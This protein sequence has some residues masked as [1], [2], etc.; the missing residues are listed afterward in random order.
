MS[1]EPIGVAFKTLGCKV[2]QVESEDI[3]ADLLGRGVVL[4]DEPDA[5]VVV[6]NTCT[7]TGEADAKA[8]KAVRHALGAATRPVVV[9]TG[10]MAALARDDLEAISERVVVEADKARVAERVAVELELRDESS[11]GASHSGRG[12][13]PAPVRPRARGGGP[14][15]HPSDAEGRGRLRCL[16][17]L[18]H[19]ALRSRS[20]LT[21]PASQA[22][23][24][25]ERLVAAGVREIVL[26][27]INLGRYQ[28]GDHDLAD[29]ILAVAAS[30]VERLRLSSIEPMDLTDRLLDTLGGLSSACPHLH[31]PLQSGSDAVLEKMSRRYSAADYAEAISKARAMIPGLAVTTDVIAG[32]PSETELDHQASLDLCREI[33]FSKLHVFRYSERSGTPAASMPD[34]VPPGTR[35]ARAGALRDLDRELQLAFASAHLGEDVEVLVERVNES[36][37]GVFL[38]G[39][40]TPDYLKAEIEARTRLEVG[41]IVRARVVRADRVP[42]RAVE[43]RAT[44]LGCTDR[45]GAGWVVTNGVN[46]A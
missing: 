31:V 40:T 18:L 7:V 34:P 11:S 10:C 1:G 15:S 25:A 14:L 39:G 5:A 43:Q 21:S 28:D 12:A 37:S 36:P 16:L 20:P 4:V 33:G 29:V 2:N 19:R 23:A 38:A 44:E 27:G 46:R 26:T 13:R 42:V 8:R 30:G 24:E 3:A 17:Q 45:P 32:F 9:V 35:A 6:I 41:E 22:A